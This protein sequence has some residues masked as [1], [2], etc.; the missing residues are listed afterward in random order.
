MAAGPRTVA[1]PVMSVKAGPQVTEL[2]L[3]R[4]LVLAR[5]Q[6]PARGHAPAL[7]QVQARATERSAVEVATK[8]LL[9]PEAVWPE[10]V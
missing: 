9:S 5:V 6:V 1:M 7:V 4:T 3:S 10:V 2:M 8:V